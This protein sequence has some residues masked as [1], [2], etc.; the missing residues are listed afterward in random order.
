MAETLNPFF[1]KA[2]VTLKLVASKISDWAAATVTAALSVKITF[3]MIW[4]LSCDEK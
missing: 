3:F 1:T 4:N 2:S